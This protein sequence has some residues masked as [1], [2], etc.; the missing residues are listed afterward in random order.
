MQSGS[1]NIG[2][3]FEFQSGNHRVRVIGGWAFSSLV[4]GEKD[5]QFPEMD[6]R[7]VF[8]HLANAGMSIGS[9]SS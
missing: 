5:M 4:H 2:M 7:R 8:V 9:G 6:T 1:D 3:H